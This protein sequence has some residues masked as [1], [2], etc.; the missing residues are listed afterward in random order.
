MSWYNP[1]T[2]WET[3]AEETIVDQAGLDVLLLALARADAG[4]GIIT[5]ADY[6]ALRDTFADVHGAAALEAFDASAP[7]VPAGR[8]PRLHGRIGHRHDRLPPFAP[9][10]ASACA[11]RRRRGGAGTRNPYDAHDIQAR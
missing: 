1:F 6:Q 8:H 3:A 11:C 4:A 5:Q 9:L 10:A 2:W 7:A